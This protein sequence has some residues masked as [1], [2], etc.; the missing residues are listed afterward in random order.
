LWGH[1]LMMS[2]VLG[3]TEMFEAKVR[4][5]L[6]FKIHFSIDVIYEWPQIPSFGLI[7]SIPWSINLWS[8]DKI[9]IVRKSRTYCYIEA[10]VVI[11]Y[12][13]SH[14]QSH[15]SRLISLNLLIILNRW[16]FHHANDWDRINIITLWLSLAP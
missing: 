3:G 4:K 5:I 14:F 1:L 13:F 2:H 7:N 8:I 12:E 15:K 10:Y 9:V 6:N 16:N 11:N